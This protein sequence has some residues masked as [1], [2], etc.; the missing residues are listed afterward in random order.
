MMPMG[1]A[2]LYYDFFVDNDIICKKQFSVAKR[3]DLLSFQRERLN[4]SISAIDSAQSLITVPGVC[5]SRSSDLVPVIPS[6]SYS[7]LRC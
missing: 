4:T 6:Q 7:I 2:F 1:L 3:A 5:T